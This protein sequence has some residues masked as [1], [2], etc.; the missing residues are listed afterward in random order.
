MTGES[1]G[2]EAVIGGFQ[3]RSWWGSQE[4][5]WIAKVN[6]GVIS[7]RVSQQSGTQ[8]FSGAGRQMLEPVQKKNGEPEPLRCQLTGPVIVRWC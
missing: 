5:H 1:E 2:L 6:P 7:Y 3:D 4:G 8:E